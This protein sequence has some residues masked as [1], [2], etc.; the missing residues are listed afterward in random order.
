M[1]LIDPNHQGQM[2]LAGFPWNGAANIQPSK[3][4]TQK[5]TV[6]NGSFPFGISQ[7]EQDGMIGDGTSDIPGGLIR[8]I[9]AAKNWTMGPRRRLQTHG[10]RADDGQYGEP[11]T[12]DGDYVLWKPDH[13]PWWWSGLKQSDENFPMNNGNRINYLQSAKFYGPGSLLWAFSRERMGSDNA[14]GAL[15]PKVWEDGEWK[16]RISHGVG[17]FGLVNDFQ[18]YR[19]QNKVSNWPSEYIRNRKDSSGSDMEGQWYKTHLF[20]DYP[21]SMLVDWHNYVLRKEGTP[22]VADGEPDLSECSNCEWT[23]N[24]EVPLRQLELGQI[25]YISL[26][27]LDTRGIIRTLE[28]EQIQYQN[29]IKDMEMCTQYKLYPSAAPSTNIVAL[30]P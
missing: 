7:A 9:E 21:I 28:W 4:I 23:K 13:T 27:D 6:Q 15:S 5:Q 1:D 8:F 14:F 12:K 25:P 30:L 20:A 17:A 10:V 29:F 19:P 22:G 16:D 26:L 24:V 3:V 11:R 18:F 2:G